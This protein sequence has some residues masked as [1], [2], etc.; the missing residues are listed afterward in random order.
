[1]FKTLK[2]LWEKKDIATKIWQSLKSIPT[3][4]TILSFFYLQYLKYSTTLYPLVFFLENLEYLGP[5]MEFFKKITP[6]DFQA[7]NFTPSIS[8][9]F[10]S[11]SGKKNTKN[12]WKWRNLHRWQKFYTAA[13]IDGIDKSHLCIQNV[14]AFLIIFNSDKMGRG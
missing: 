2:P 3:P 10:N 7:N 9:N 11:V 13:G 12:E 6:P 1:M 4:H 8:P 14:Y 5:D